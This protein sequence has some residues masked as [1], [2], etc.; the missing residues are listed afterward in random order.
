MMTLWQQ[1][2]CVQ[3]YCGLIYGVKHDDKSLRI[4]CASLWSSQYFECNCG[5]WEPRSVAGF[6]MDLVANTLK[7]SG[8]KR[9]FT[10]KIIS[11]TVVIDDFGPPSNWK[12]IKNA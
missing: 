2:L 6:D 12:F 4:P 11:G 10:E 1:I 8:V 5:Y 7:L 3:I 9:R